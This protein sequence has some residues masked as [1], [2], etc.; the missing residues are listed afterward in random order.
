MKKDG[1]LKEILFITNLFIKIMI[2]LKITL[3]INTKN[4]WTT[5][6]A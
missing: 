3:N 2:F 1:I 6:R 5:I 4:H